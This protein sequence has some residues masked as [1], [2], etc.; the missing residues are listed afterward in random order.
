MFFAA[1][2]QNTCAA[3]PYWPR[4]AILETAALIKDP[5]AL[6]KKILSAQNIS[7]I[8]RDQT[9]FDWLEG[10]SD[11]LKKVLEHPEFKE[12]LAWENEWIAIQDKKHADDISIIGKWL[13]ICVSKYGSPVRNIRL[14]INP[15]K[16][17]YSADYHMV[18]DSFIYTSGTLRRDSVL[19]EFLHHLL[20]PY[21][22]A[23]AGLIAQTPVQYPDL[24]ASYYSAGAL[25]AFEEHA[26]RTLTGMILKND[27]PNALDA[28]IYDIARRH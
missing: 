7:D 17:V 8:E 3:Y 6:C 9:L 13:E 20:H 2:K 18:D 21:V 14:V 28:F 26:V 10:F 22:A 11:A 25:N 5:E 19:H 24:D 23:G 1:A 12:Y 16:C 15:I 27:L 4:A